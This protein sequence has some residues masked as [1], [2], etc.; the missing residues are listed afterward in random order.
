VREREKGRRG[1]EE[2]KEAKRGREKRKGEE[3]EREGERR[4]GVR[5][6]LPGVEPGRHGKPLPVPGWVWSVAG[7]PVARARLSRT[8]GGLRSGR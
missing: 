5:E 6:G 4:K 2:R 1:R 3:G 8:E 7:T